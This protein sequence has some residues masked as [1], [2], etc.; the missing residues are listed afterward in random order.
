V[1]AVEGENVTRLPGGQAWYPGVV[2]FGD[3]MIPVI[4]LGR[5]IGARQRGAANTIVVVQEDGARLGLLVDQLGDV[6]EIGAGDIVEVQVAA[7][8]GGAGGARVARFRDAQD[9]TLP[10]VDVGTLLGVLR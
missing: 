6:V 5:W 2:R 3:E 4:D 8:G 7:A 10:V 9:A 1:E